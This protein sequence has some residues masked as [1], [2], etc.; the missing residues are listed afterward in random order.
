MDWQK[1]LIILGIFVNVF[2]S[3]IMLYPYIKTTKDIEGELILNMD[4]KNGN[5]TQKKHIKDKRLGIVGFILFMIGLVF[6]IVGVL[7]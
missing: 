2:A 6:Q 5:F 4:I 1:I 3:I 7:T